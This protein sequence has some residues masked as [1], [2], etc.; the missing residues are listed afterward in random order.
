MLFPAS[1]VST[2][3]ARSKSS[4]PPSS[5]PRSPIPKSSVSTRRRR[6]VLNSNWW[7]HRDRLDLLSPDRMTYW[8]PPTAITTVKPINTGDCRM[9]SSGIVTVNPIIGAAMSVCD[10]LVDSCFLVRL[11]MHFLLNQT[12]LDLKWSASSRC[13]QLGKKKFFGVSKKD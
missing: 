8:P 6:P 9:C 5:W 10:G 13:Q 1:L 7:E 11:R 4:R 12:L 3:R 2:M